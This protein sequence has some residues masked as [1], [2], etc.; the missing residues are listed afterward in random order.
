MI[1][2]T[3]TEDHLIVDLD[4]H[5]QGVDRDSQRRKA[6]RWE[7]DYFGTKGKVK[8]MSKREADNMIAEIF[9]AHG[10]PV[11]VIK[12]MRGR[13]KCCWRA[14]FD[15]GDRR[16]TV[17]P[18]IRLR[19]WGL[20]PIVILHEVAHGLNTYADYHRAGHGAEWLA[21]YI[22]LLGKYTEYD[23]RLL[24]ISARKAGLKVAKIEES[25]AEFQ[26]FIDLDM[27]SLELLANQ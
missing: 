18:M 9:S 27:S 12:H 17:L 14:G 22:D 4:M 20:N 25:D 1:L 2:P 26:G 8:I 5:M 24:E 6:Y 19:D 7:N 3:P 23:A 10:L 21:I 16:G 11:P 13:G 15:F